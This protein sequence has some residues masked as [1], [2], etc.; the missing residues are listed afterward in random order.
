M[1]D[2]EYPNIHWFHSF[3][4]GQGEIINGIKPLNVLQFEADAILEH[5]LTGRTVLD[6]GAWDVLLLRSRPNVEAHPA[7][8][9]QIISAGPARAGKPAGLRLYPC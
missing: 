6:I 2:L 8:L 9:L 7:W 4:L 5:D 3:D 1:P